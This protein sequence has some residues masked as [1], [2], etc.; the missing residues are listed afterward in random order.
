MEF[1]SGPAAIEGGRAIL[2]AKI[3][4]YPKH[5]WSVVQA[6]LG[7]AEG[8]MIN[9]TR[10]IRLGEWEWSEDEADWDWTASP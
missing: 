2:Q 8:S 6:L 4:F 1:L 5:K 10:V 9:D 3:D 7:V